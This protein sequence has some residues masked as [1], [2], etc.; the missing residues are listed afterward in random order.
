MELKVV[1][2]LK[3]KFFPNY[4]ELTSGWLCVMQSRTSKVVYKFIGTHQPHIAGDVVTGSETS[5]ENIKLRFLVD[6]RS[7]EFFTKMATPEEL[8]RAEFIRPWFI[9]WHH[10]GDTK[11]LVTVS[12]KASKKVPPENVQLVM[13]NRNHYRSFEVSYKVMRYTVKDK[14]GVKSGIKFVLIKLEPL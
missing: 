2:N 9:Q 14:A 12:Y 1:P 13:D 10:S 6:E 7:L 11:G 5:G 4:F 8:N 3:T